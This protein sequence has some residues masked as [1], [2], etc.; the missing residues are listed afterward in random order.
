[1]LITCA[2]CEKEFE[3]NTEFN[4]EYQI[5]NDEYVCPCCS[6]VL[7]LNTVNGKIYTVPSHNSY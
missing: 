6:T 4:N 1:M 3:I 2:V 5:V 7:E